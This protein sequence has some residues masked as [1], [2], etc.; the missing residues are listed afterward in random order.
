MGKSSREGKDVVLE[1][2]K[3]LPLENVLD[4]GAGSGTYKKLFLKNKLPDTAHWTAVEA[5]EQYIKDFDLESM[6]NAVINQDIRKVEFSSLGT[7]DIT[8]MGDVLEHVTKE[9]AIAIVDQVMAISKY[10]IISIPIVH[11]PQSERHN[12]PYEVHVKDDWSDQEVKS[13][14]SKY[15]K[16]S[17]AGEKIGVYW[18]E[19]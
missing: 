5:W 8:F 3:D 18:L 15:I 9:D 17:H 19:L 2:V 13:T 11:W 6:Y 1:W 10:A 12:N 7:F 16:K 4:I 14:F